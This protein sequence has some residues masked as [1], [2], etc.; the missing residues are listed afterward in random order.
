MFP[1]IDI[2]W[3][4]DAADNRA[5]KWASSDGSGDK[6][7]IDWEKYGSTKFYVDPKN[8][9]NFDGYKL[10]FVDIID[11]NPKAVKNA[12]A[13]VRGA[14]SGARGGVDIPEKDKE[15]IMKEVEQYEKKIE[16][17]IG[18]T[19]KQLESK[20]RFYDEPVETFGLSVFNS[21][22]KAIRFD[23]PELSVGNV[24]IFL[25]VTING[26]SKFEE[27]VYNQLKEIIQENIGEITD[28]AGDQITIGVESKPLSGDIGN[29]ALAALQTVLQQFSQEL[30]AVQQ[31]ATA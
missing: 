5:R 7:K 13:A 31:V 16:K 10:G 26:L 25:A 22:S 15:Q 29:A 20:L 23:T 24:G 19:S 30:Q 9:E 11:G 21:S 4:S 1:V 8:K 14:L 28:F 6:E 27:P 17:E 3:D 12:I 2:E 18:Y